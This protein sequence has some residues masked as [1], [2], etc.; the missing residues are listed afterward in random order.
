[1]DFKRVY[2]ADTVRWLRACCVLLI[3]ITVS[4]EGM[5]QQLERENTVA[6]RA[7]PGLDADGMPLGGF[8]LFPAVGLGLVHNDNVFATK[9]MQ[10][11][12]T[13]ALLQPELRLTSESSRHRAAIGAEADFA[14]YSDFD[15]EDY[16]DFDIYAEGGLEI[17][18]GRLEAELRH[19]DKHEERTSADDARGIEPTE[20]TLDKIAGSYT[21]K[22]GR[23]IAKV[24]GGY[25]KFE[26]DDT[27]TLTAP[28][29]NADRDRNASELGLRLA[30]EMSP[31]YALYAEVKAKQIEYDQKF[32]RNGFERSSDGF[33]AVVGALLDFSGQTFGEVFAGYLRQ[34]YD[35]AR[36]GT[37]DG[38]TFGGK[39]TWNVTGLTT[40]IFSGRRGI[41]STTIVGASGIETTEFGF[42]AD[43]ELLRSLVL[44]LELS[45]GNEDF[46]GID[47]DDD[48]KSL[49][50]GG[51]Y[52]MNRY[53]NL[54]FGYLY[55]DRDTSPANS[56]GREFE[57][58]Q[59]FLRLVGQL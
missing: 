54:E 6:D 24:D 30:R 44:N 1:M 11:S 7:R 49:L 19:S 29:S 56:G 45:L 55:R 32:D 9:E 40:L 26:F 27:A 18:N 46:E 25:R 59:Y 20:F 53:L 36:F 35:D 21:W 50:L 23:W 13:A 14:R 47:R 41:D 39:V 57:V 51:K 3:C 52:F 5:A 4:G 10:Q 37:A 2:F 48:V 58:S 12:D 22:P 33:S 28:I 31:N 16:D 8:R 42:R 15:G 43:H 34:D 38:P 17:G